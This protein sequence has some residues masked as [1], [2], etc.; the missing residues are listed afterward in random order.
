MTRS[1]K[2]ILP[3]GALLAIVAL[4]VVVVMVS[5]SA[6]DLL[7]QSARLLAET[8]NGHAILSFD[9]QGPEESRSGSLEVWGKK[10]MGPNGEP[11]F[12]LEVLQSSQEEAQGVIAVSDGTQ[13]WLWRPAENTVYV[14]TVEELKEKMREH[15]QNSQYEFEHDKPQFEE[16]A[17]PET[18]EEA[19]D[20]LLEYFE[21]EKAGTD[22]L[23]GGSA[24]HLRLIPIPEMMP[25]EIRAN[26]GLLHIWLR[27]S[28]SAPLAA[29]Y[30]DGAVGSGQISASVLELNQGIED[31]VFTFVI[32]EGAEVVQLA[33]LA[34]P[35][36]SAE[37]AAK[38]AEFDVLTPSK[39]PSAA[40]LENTV[41]LRGAVVQRYKLPDGADFTV[42][43]GAADAGRTPENDRG[44]LITV[45]GVQGILYGDESG[46]RTLLT[47][48]EGGVT[49]WVGG[50][51]TAD[52]ALEIANS[53]Q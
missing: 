29:E 43:Q 28:D 52:D 16:G 42:A 7:Y 9:V 22:E 47:W 33:D 23:A 4:A 30:S 8:T 13:G 38:V 49:F 20:K 34:P 44:E 11:A 45:R 46:T 15:V 27:T 6:D 36:L 53:L 50:D 24:H 37:E 35:A 26:G 17:K 19:V 1:R 5:A 32:P 2:I 51:L 18:P 10:D 21:A 3:L 25:D 12:R 14:G 40:R 39:L 41:E 31:S 48:S